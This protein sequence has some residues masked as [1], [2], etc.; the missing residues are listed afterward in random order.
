M[1][2]DQLALP[3]I[4]SLLSIMDNRISLSSKMSWKAG[5]EMN[6]NYTPLD[7]IVELAAIGR[8]ENPLPRHEIFA[9]SSGNEFAFCG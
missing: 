3:A 4:V 8:A 9:S 6:K 7:S 2:I 1:L 5:V